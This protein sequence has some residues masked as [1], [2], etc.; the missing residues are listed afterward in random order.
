DNGRLVRSALANERG[1]VY[2]KPG[3]VDADRVGLLEDALAAVGPDDSSER[4]E[5]LARLGDEL[6]F[7]GDVQRRKAVSDEALEVVRRLDAPESL[8][9]VVAERAIAI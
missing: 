3:H 6:Q 9:G 8:I 2:S 4:A 5:L 7:A 1:R